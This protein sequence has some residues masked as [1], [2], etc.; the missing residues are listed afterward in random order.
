M[1]A[2]VWINVARILWGFNVEKARDAAGKTIE[3]DIVSPFLLRRKTRITTQC[4]PQDAFTDGFNSQPQP[5]SCS[6][7]VRSTKHAEIIE[8]DWVDAQEALKQFTW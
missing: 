7:K 8:A 6:I 4:T 5:F 1:L 2:S 3:V